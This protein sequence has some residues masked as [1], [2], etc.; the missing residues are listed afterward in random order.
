MRASLEGPLLVGPCNCDGKN[1]DRD[2]SEGLKGLQPFHNYE[3]AA[4]WHQDIEDCARIE[5]LAQLQPLLIDA[6]RSLIS[7]N[8]K[9]PSLS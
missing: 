4:C 6:P 7:S 2:V 8:G 3:A 1:N 5:S 9:S